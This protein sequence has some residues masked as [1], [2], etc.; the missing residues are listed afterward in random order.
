VYR[1]PY[2]FGVPLGNCTAGPAS[3]ADTAAR[4]IGFIQSPFIIL[5]S[6]PGALG[7]ICSVLVF[8]GASW[9]RL[10]APREE[11]ARLAKDTEQQA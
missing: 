2:D 10:V 5:S 11:K 8:C 7:A 4:I 1:N 3:A 6:I 9:R